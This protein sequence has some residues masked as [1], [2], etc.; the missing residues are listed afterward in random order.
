ME[1]TKWQYKFTN[2]KRA[3][4]KLS[5]AVSLT[6]ERELNDLENQGLIQAFEFTHELAGKVI[7]EFLKSKGD[8]EIYGSKDATRK[9]FEMG[10]IENGEDWMEMIGQRNLTS[11]TYHEENAKAIV[12][13]TINR[14]FVLFVDFERKMNS[15]HS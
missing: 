9:A 1:H 11:H 14:Y 8:Y 13:L 7:A 10:L 3:L 2:Y 12:D 4:S 6:N 15:I 5:E